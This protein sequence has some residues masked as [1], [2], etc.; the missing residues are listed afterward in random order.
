MGAS[1]RRFSVILLAVLALSGCRHRLRDVQPWI[2]PGA[3]RFNTL[4]FAQSGIKPAPVLRYVEAWEAEW[5]D[6]PAIEPIPANAHAGHRPLV[7][8]FDH[9]G[10]P[11]IVTKPLARSP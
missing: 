4:V 2:W 11:E 6:V 9:D 5:F 1:L 7:T 3:N 10:R 8:D